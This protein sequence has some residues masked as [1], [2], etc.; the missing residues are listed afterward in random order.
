[1]FGGLLCEGCCGNSLSQS[2]RCAFIVI[3]HPRASLPAIASRSGEAG[4]PISPH[5]LRWSTFA[6]E[7]PQLHMLRLASAATS[8]RE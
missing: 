6:V 8:T 3:L 2:L 4:G 1:M 7:V 5:L